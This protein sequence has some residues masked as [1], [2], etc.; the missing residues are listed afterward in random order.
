MRIMGLAALIALCAPVITVVMITV[1]E[2]GHTVVARLLGDGR[3]TF[4]LVGN[5]CIGCNLYDSARQSPW[6][7]VAVNLGGLLFTAALTLAAVAVLGWHRRPRWL[8]RWLACEII[9][10][11]FLGDFI[12][13][14][15][16]ALQQLPVPA[17]EPLGWG[18]GYTDLD[19]AVSF[20][21]QATGLS[22][23]V[24][25]T[26]GMTVAV[27]YT[28]ALIALFARAWRRSSAASKVLVNGAG[29][30]G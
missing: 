23:G 15:V 5:S 29:G 13:Q 12:M 10:I 26:I 20:G 3:A 17:R 1:H 11:C 2:I 30:G 25:A 9:A 6:G 8:P 16:Q 22:H 4:I 28:A 27:L 19:A 14:I 18:I 21:S 7:N 24:V